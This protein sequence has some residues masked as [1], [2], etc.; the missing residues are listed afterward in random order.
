ML[1]P[2]SGRAPVTTTG[3]KVN[4]YFYI[5]RIGCQAGRTPEPLVRSKKREEGLLGKALKAS[6]YRLE[7]SGKSKNKVRCERLR[8]F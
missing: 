5:L 4:K 3:L 8:M 2:A 1:T 6:G 7:A